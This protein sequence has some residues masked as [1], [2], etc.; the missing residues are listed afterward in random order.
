MFSAACVSVEYDEAPGLGDPC[1]R[2]D[3]SE[4]LYC[5]PTMRVC[6]E[7]P[8]IG[9]ACLGTCAEGATCREDPPGSSEAVCVEATENGLACMGHFE[10]ASQYCPA[11]FCDDLP[12][13]GESCRGTSLCAGDLICVDDIC[14]EPS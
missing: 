11:G 4:E 2:D 9:E 13:V 5:H 7:R 12:E 10:C 3:C 1:T 6:T 14:T 8:E